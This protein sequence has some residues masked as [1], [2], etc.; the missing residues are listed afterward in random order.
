MLL[1]SEKLTELELTADTVELRISDCAE[2][3]EQRRQLVQD[4]STELE[5]NRDELSRVRGRHASLEALHQAS[6]HQ[7]T[8]TLEW[9]EQQQLKDHRRLMDT[10]QVSAGWERAVETVLGDSLQAV[11][12]DSLDPVAD[13]LDQLEQGSLILL[14]AG[15]TK[16]FSPSLNE[17]PLLS[18]KVVN[19][20]ESMALLAGIY[21]ADSLTSA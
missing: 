14:E 2:A 9:L 1:L 18:D 17:L 16:R 21:A 4:L 19:G 7:D 10:L 11:C 13:A 5:H 8:G 6:V 12:L 3:V 15:A 20:Q